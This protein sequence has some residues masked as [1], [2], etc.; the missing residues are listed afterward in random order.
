M[1]V[2]WKERLG[3]GVFSAVLLVAG[4]GCIQKAERN[5]GGGELPVYSRGEGADEVGWVFATEAEYKR[6]LVVAGWFCI[7][8]G[9]LFGACA[10][11]K[12]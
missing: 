4:V 7:I 1:G 2:T 10:L 9:V 8:G 3:C 11:R 6:E 12:L 5:T